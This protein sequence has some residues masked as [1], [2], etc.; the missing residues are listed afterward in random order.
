MNALGKAE[1]NWGIDPN[2]DDK[3]HT[4]YYTII[5]MRSY[6]NRDCPRTALF[7]GWSTRVGFL[8]H[9]ILSLAIG[10]SIAHANTSLAIN[11]ES[12]TPTDEFASVPIDAIRCADLRVTSMNENE[13]IANVSPKLGKILARLV[14][15]QEDFPRNE[16]G[17]DDHNGKPPIGMK[18]REEARPNTAVPDKEGEKSDRTRIGSSVD[19]RFRMP[20][21]SSRFEAV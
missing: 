17:E 4:H 5:V 20:M 10:C 13:T 14:R 6:M 3:G 15:A 11:R 18:P 9:W 8:A 16:R 2:G 19:L 1:R 7:S 12:R 21:A